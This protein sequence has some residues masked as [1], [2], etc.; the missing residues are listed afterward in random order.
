MLVNNLELIVPLLP[1]EGDYYFCH[2][3]IVCRAKD[4]KEEKVKEGDMHIDSYRV[5]D[6]MTEDLFDVIVI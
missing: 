2:M 6:Y 5:E 4:H 3:Q 1:K